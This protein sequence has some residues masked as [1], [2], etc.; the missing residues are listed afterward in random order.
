MLFFPGSKIQ[1][2]G[3]WEIMSDATKIKLNSKTLLSVFG[4]IFI[5]SDVRS[6]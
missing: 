1:G 2:K 3:S 4:W 5:A 6:I